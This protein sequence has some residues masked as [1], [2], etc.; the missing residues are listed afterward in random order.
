[1]SNS[2][3]KRVKE[4][5]SKAMSKNNP[6]KNSNKAIDSNQS[7]GSNYYMLPILIIICVIPLIAKMKV[8]N[9]NLSQFPWFPDQLEQIDFFLYYKHRIFVFV[10]VIMLLAVIV[11]LS[12]TYKNIRIKPVFVP[13]I[14]YMVLTILSTI[15]SKYSS[16]SLSGSF[17]MFESV[18][19]ILGYCITVYYVFLFLD[20][21]R[22]FKLIIR[23]LIIISLIMSILGIFQFIG[24][25][26]IKSEIAK[27]LMVPLQYRA[28]T[29]LQFNF[30]NNRVYLT[31][32]NP[33]YVGVFTALITPI[34]IVLLF[35]QKKIVPIIIFS[36]SAIGLI[37]CAIG[38]QS[39]SGFIGLGV[40]IIC[41]VILMWRY[42][43]KRYY[44]TI[45]I[46]L[47]LIISFIVVNNYTDN[48]LINRL[49]NSFN[50]VTSESALND[51]H[52]EDDYVSITYNNNEIRFKS[53]KNSDNTYSI[54]VMDSNNQPIIA[55]FNGTTLE[56]M[57]V[58]SRFNNITYGN[59]GAY[60]GAFYIGV[61]GQYYV[62]T[63]QT[64]DG[65]YYYVNRYGKLD[66][67]YTAES[68]VFT[69]MEK[70]ASNRGYI[71]SRTIP[72]LKDYL[73]LGS[74]PDTFVMAFPQQD[75][76]N[77]AKY[78]YSTELLN[79]PH[80][81][82]LQM[83]VQTGVISLIAFLVFYGMYFASSIKLYM[84]GVYNNFYSRFGVA[85]FIG[86][87]S[88]MIVGLANDSTIN[89]APIFWTLMG[90]GIALNRKVS[91]F[92]KEEARIN[93]ESNT[94]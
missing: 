46:I 44:V 16:F 91:M 88:Y 42:L 54:S 5:S 81:M 85:V 39:L 10:A 79:K 66:K 1:M 86:T 72:L 13:L 89:T 47:L 43:L 34:I 38:S 14:I 92:K 31:L 17:E 25:D 40:S 94:K 93:Q 75:Y 19:A 67:M 51:I 83:A 73:I 35:F 57:I 48:F 29:N 61:D 18:F 33:N 53:T 62:F 21:E 69:G 26:F 68:A 3:N 52:I 11:K 90:V 24:Y 49:L 84:K 63:N 37:I 32:Y 50:P 28:T 76:F 6:N 64:D 36:L 15:F 12:K 7:S 74:G 20:T 8:Y 22:D 4:N 27:N 80:N 82:Y 59:D 45:P 9:P 41:I 55:S 77:Q 58:D 78:G 70:F 2:S 71:W 30:E 56:Y 65:T 23:Y 60:D 87:I